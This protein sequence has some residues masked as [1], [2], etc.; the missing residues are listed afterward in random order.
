MTTL[1]TG[2]GGFLGLAIVKKLCQQGETVHSFSR[3]SYPA[4]HALG[5]KQFIGDL[6]NYAQL[7]QAARGC[8]RVFHVAAKAG[9]W[10]D[11]ASYYQANVVGTDHVIQACR[12]CNISK[13]IYTSSPSVVFN[14]Q[15]MAGLNESLPYP[16][17]YETAYPATK[18]IAE[19]HVLA[20]NDAQLATVA[21]RPHLIWGPGDNHL[22]PRILARGRAGKLRKIGRFNE[23]VD[24][25]YV[26]N[27]AHAHLLAAEKLAPG[28]A[29]AGRCFFIS[30]NDPRPLWDIV[31]GIL[32]TA[33][34]PP[35]TRSIP[36]ALALLLG[37]GLEVGYRLLGK[38][39]E[40]LLTRFL[41]RELSTAH[42]FDMQA[43][44][45][46]LG[47]QPQISIEEGLDR[48]RT[49]QKSAVYN[50]TEIFG[51]DL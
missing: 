40:P 45:D 29:A 26:D 43:A 41:V 17:H 2:A 46:I 22:T 4:L 32:A 39:K 28:S 14:G 49:L 27:A 47:Y 5:V 38:E 31:D 30:Q 20:A 9:I 13:L 50:Q 15:S 3:N 23:K 44:I 36:Y 11:Y 6:G 48:L 1:V 33:D 16:D 12:H 10:G 24:C 34:L 7:E 21:L 42:W 35:V 19:Q 37:W 51:S 18:A 25:I 8:E